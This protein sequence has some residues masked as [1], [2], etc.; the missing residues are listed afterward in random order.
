[1]ALQEAGWFTRANIEIWA[2]DASP[3]AL[4]KANR[5]V[6][7]SRSFR[8]LPPAL[9]EKYFHR[10][11]AA[12]RSTRVANCA[13]IIR[14]PTYSNRAKRRTW[15]ARPSS[16]AATSSFISRPQLSHGSWPVRSL[17]AQPGYLFVGVS[18][19]LLRA[20]TA[21]DLREVGGA[22]VYVEMS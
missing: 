13:C 19:S 14:G 1:M 7:R 2:S 18:E 4:E 17:H 10:A 6:Y 21:F 11:R 9:R 3:A 8:A 22:F 12:G 16:S 15:R 20:T 5:G